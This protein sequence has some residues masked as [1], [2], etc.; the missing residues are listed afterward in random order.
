MV[1]YLQEVFLDDVLA[2]VNGVA[3]GDAIQVLA[4]IRRHGEKGAELGHQVTRPIPVSPFHLT[5]I[6]T[7]IGPEPIP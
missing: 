3:N 4:V 7:R 5:H 6:W 1:G 2:R